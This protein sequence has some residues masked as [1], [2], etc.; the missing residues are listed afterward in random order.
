MKIAILAT[1]LA[2]LAASA[3]A[4]TQTP[5]PV[6]TPLPEVGDMTCEQMQAEMTIAGQLMSQQMDPN[7]ATNIEAMQA[8]GQRQ[9]GQAGAAAMGTGLL[10]SVPG[11]GGACTAVL[12]T[13]AV[14][15]AQ[16]AEQNRERRSAMID[17][18][19][20]AT[21]GIDME[22]MTAISQRWESERCEAPQP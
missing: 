21:A 11:L 19:N 20:N 2:C 12:N 16:Q 3:G 17:S 10:C 22:R 8:D 6:E 14:R 15:Q 13:Q 1:V 7:L 9:M 18:M 4:Q 5:S